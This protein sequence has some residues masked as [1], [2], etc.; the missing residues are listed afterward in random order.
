M[1]EIKPD[2]YFCGQQTVRQ[3]LLAPWYKGPGS[4]VG[5]GT[6]VRVEW[7]GTQIPAGGV[8]L[9]SKHVRA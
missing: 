3:Y 2:K 8:F 9:I 4:V 6:K 5:I 7:N 1:Q